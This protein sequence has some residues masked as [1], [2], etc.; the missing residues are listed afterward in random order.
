MYRTSGA[1]S[2]QLIGIATAPEVVR[3]EDRLQ[4]LG[5]VVREQAHD[6]AGADAA[7]VQSGGERRRAIRHLLVRDDSSP[8]TQ[9]GF[10]GVRLA[11]CSRT[12]NQF[13]SALTTRPPRAYPHARPRAGCGLRGG[14]RDETV[15]EPPLAADPFEPVEV[16]TGSDGLERQRVGL[17]EHRRRAP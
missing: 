14:T 13:M 15:G 11:W 3:G 8:K 16:P 12:P 5:A 4:E 10:V 17:L 1:A 6:V 9:S 2:R 7:L